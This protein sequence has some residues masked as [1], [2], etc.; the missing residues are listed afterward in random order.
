MKYIIEH[1][2]PEL[3]PW[4]ELEYKNISKIVGKENLLITR[5]RKEDL[6]K[7]K[8]YATVT[9]K[10]TSSMPEINTPKTCVLDPNATSV[11]LPSD[12]DVF[13]TIILGGILGNEP[14]RARTAEELIFTKATRRH[15]GKEQFPTDN[16]A[17]VMNKILT[18]TPFEELK[19][20]DHVEIELDEGESTILPFRYVLIN[21]KPMISKEVIE[22]L[23][24]E[25]AFEDLDDE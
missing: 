21:G 20:Q 9:T 3:F 18:G 16:A 2:E 15:L 6:D 11:L 25:F 19:F 23:K 8:D 14:P 22:I 10:G 12:K 13:D 24:E 5:L 17:Y 1:L 7:L 4:C